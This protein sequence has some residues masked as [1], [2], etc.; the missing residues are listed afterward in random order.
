MT[1]SAYG[2]HDHSQLK[3]GKQPPDP[4]RMARAIKMAS[5]IDVK[6]VTQQ[7][8][9]HPPT[10]DNYLQYL[11]ANKSFGLYGNNNFGV[12]GP[13]MIANGRRLSSFLSGSYDEPTQDDVFDLYRR[14]GNPNFDPITGADDKGVN[15]QTMLEQALKTGFGKDI[16]GNERELVA[17]AQVDHGNLNELRVA[18]YKFDYVCVGVVLDTA[19]QDQS[20]GS[21]PTWSYVDSSTWG[22]HDILVAKYDSDSAVCVSWALFIDMLDS[23]MSRQMDEAWV[24]IWRDQYDKLTDGEKVAL[25]REFEVATGKPFPLIQPDPEPSPTPFTNLDLEL[26]KKIAASGFLGQSHHKPANDVAHALMQWMIAKG[27]VS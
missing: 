26:V 3:L 10:D 13:T 11:D 7:I 9:Y 5:F 18:I 19:Q 20:D 27:Y 21:N 4:T 25:A 12:C 8:E 14:S 17:F 6:A 15:N 23:F 2:I 16:E 22:G 1:E 24:V